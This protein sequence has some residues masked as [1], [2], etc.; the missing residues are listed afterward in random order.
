MRSPYTVKFSARLTKMKLR[1]CDQH[2]F[3]TL[4]TPEIF[5]NPLST[6]FHRNG[7]LFLIKYK[8][9]LWSWFATSSWWISPISLYFAH[10]PLG[11]TTL[12]STTPLYQRVQIRNLFIFILRVCCCMGVRGISYF[13]AARSLTGCR[14]RYT[15]IFHPRGSSWRNGL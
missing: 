2:L 7:V 12:V 4:Q 6:S 3:S 11:K 13:S 5:S 14:E 8:F 1:Q 9:Y 10:T 15:T